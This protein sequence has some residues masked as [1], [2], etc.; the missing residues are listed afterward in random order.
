[1]SSWWPILC[2]PI[3]SR[4]WEVNW[5]RSIPVK[6]HSSTWYWL[7]GASRPAHRGTVITGRILE[8]HMNVQAEKRLGFIE[9]SDIIEKYKIIGLKDFANVMSGSFSLTPVI[10]IWWL[11]IFA[12]DIFEACWN[13]CSRAL[14]KQPLSPPHC[15]ILYQA[16]LPIWEDQLPWEK[17][18]KY[19]HYTTI[20]KIAVSHWSLTI[21]GGKMWGNCFWHSLLLPK[22]NC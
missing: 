18:N 12:R 21:D 22:A 19:K 11:C 9:N 6:R 10:Y 5:S 20:F 7:R 16:R 13:W 1:M 3:P 2:T 14:G 4:S 8:L 17:S 15:V